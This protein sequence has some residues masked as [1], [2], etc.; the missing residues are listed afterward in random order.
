[1]TREITISRTI[2]EFEPYEGTWKINVITVS[3]ASEAFQKLT[4]G[5]NSR[6]KV[7]YVNALMIA[8]IDAPWT[9]TKLNTQ[10]LQQMPYKI[11]RMLMD[12]VLELNETSVEEANFTASS[13]SATP[14]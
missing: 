11:Y 4:S 2:G 14:Q 6:N 12:A 8:S 3:Q 13:P 7:D 9:N 5:A 10:A 1:M